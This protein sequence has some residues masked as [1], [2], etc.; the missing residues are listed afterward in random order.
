[1]FMFL[2]GFDASAYA[3]ILSDVNPTEVE[4]SGKRNKQNA[5]PPM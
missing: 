1:M 3:Q 5:Y 4:A 2:S